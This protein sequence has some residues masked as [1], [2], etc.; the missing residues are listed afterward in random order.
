VKRLHGQRHDEHQDRHQHE[1]REAEQVGD[2]ERRHAAGL[3]AVD[4]KSIG[5]PT[6]L[7][8]HE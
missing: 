3:G 2:P 5:R 8:S 1:Q 6:C 7:R 4:G